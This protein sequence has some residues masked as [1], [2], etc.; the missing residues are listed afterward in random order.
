MPMGQP[1]SSDSK[2]SEKNIWNPRDSTV[3]ALPND[4]VLGRGEP[5]VMPISHWH[6]QIEIN[7]VETGSTRYEMCGREFRIGPGDIAL[8]W[9]GLPH[10]LADFE[11]GT[12]ME[13]IHLPLV[14][15]FRLR[16]SDEIREKLMHGAALIAT[17]RAEEDRCAFARMCRYFR[18]DDA[19][20]KRHATEEL[21]LRIERIALE[22]Y[23][24]VDLGTE[25]DGALETPDQKSFD[26]IRQILGFIAEHFRENID[27][28]T[29]ADNASL[30]PKYLMSLF[31][32]STGVTL[33]QYVQLLRL[34]YAQALLLEDEG[35]ILTVAMESGF[36]SLSH[37]NRSFRKHTG[38]KP[39]EYRLGTR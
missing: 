39:T 2:I 35:S 13:A 36:G 31:K 7:Y 5:G 9:G 8:F 24:L 12:R 3:E 22:S 20:R 16:L 37:F 6:A 28:S 38:M 29:I 15:F 25:R 32:K 17:E 14:Q 10:R 4:I 26:K 33:N 1:T 34:S 19:E 27:A 21:L 18:S 11:E 23:E 30:H